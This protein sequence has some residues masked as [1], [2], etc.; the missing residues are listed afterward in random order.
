MRK[1]VARISKKIRRAKYKETRSGNIDYRIQ[2]IP[3]SAVQKE[4]SDRKEM[5]KILIQQFETHPNRDSL[6]EDLNKTEEFNPSSEKSKELITSVVCSLYW[7][8]G[9]MY[10]VRQMH[11]AVGKESTV[12]G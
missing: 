8:V 5:V 6:I 7:E 1:L 9:I 12:E 10:T 2:G 4:D 3:H 11:A